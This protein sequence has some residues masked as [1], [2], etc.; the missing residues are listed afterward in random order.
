MGGGGGGKG[1]EKREISTY[2]PRISPVTLKRGELNYLLLRNCVSQMHIDDKFDIYLRYS[3]KERTD[4][5]IGE[6]EEL[7]ERYKDEGVGVKI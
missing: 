4:W 5:L 7:I 2:F 6:R 1:G 3:H